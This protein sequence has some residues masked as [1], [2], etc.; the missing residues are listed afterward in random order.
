MRLL[1]RKQH[2]AAAEQFLLAAAQEPQNWRLPNDAGVCFFQAGRYA[3]A[4][5]CYESAMMMMPDMATVLFNR[6][7]V[8]ATVG[9]HDEA[10]ASF[11]N[12]LQI[13]RIHPGAYLEIG[14]LHQASG[15]LEDAIEAYDTALQYGGGDRRVSG[16]ALL[17]KAR[18]YL[19][20]GREDLAFA[21]VDQLATL[22]DAGTLAKLAQEILDTARARASQIVQRAIEV[23]P[24]HRVAA[25]LHK[26]LSPPPKKPRA[27]KPRVRPET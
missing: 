21:Q 16:L 26:K 19:A 23:N 13:D 8:L 12:V 15:R 3:E 20:E 11:Q 17:N 14:K 6:A 24:E 7:L 1:E 5:R 25:A 9:R 18:I 27:K 10:F 2:A 4:L 22:R